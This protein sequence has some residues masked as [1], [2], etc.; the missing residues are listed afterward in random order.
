MPDRRH[1]FPFTQARL[2]TLPAPAEGR[3]TWYDSKTPGL[4]LRKTYTGAAA[5]YLYRWHTGKP[6]R[7]H[8]GAF[9]ALSLTNARDAAAAAMGDMAKGAEPAIRRAR[10]AGESRWPTSGPTTSISTPGRTSARGRW[11]SSDTTAT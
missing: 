8:L 7:I 9:P 2:K 3:E 4:C 1:R 6:T 11:T 5:F 10:R